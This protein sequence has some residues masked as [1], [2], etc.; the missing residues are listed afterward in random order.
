MS[1]VLQKSVNRVREAGTF[2]QGHTAGQCPRPIWDQGCLTR[3]LS[4]GG[5]G[6]EDQGFRGR[7]GFRDDEDQGLGLVAGVKARAQKWMR[8]EA[9]LSGSSGPPPLDSRFAQSGHSSRR[10][11]KNVLSDAEPGL[12]G[13]GQK[14]YSQPSWVPSN[15]KCLSGVD[16]ASR[17]RKS[18]WRWG[19]GV[20]FSLGT[21]QAEPCPKMLFRAHLPSCLCTGWVFLFCT[22]V[23]P[24]S[25]YPA[26]GR[27]PDE[28][29]SEHEGL[30]LENGSSQPLLQGW[31]CFPCL[32]QTHPSGQPRAR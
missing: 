18:A 22:H 1:I 24:H 29:M 30:A 28:L 20:P 14:E 8:P 27:G 10:V 3:K 4:C 25:C 17:N 16:L 13:R 21:A 26:Y 23:C 12:G 19:R 31:R 15:T 2:A 32:D 5:G 11:R 9:W 6:G 7:G